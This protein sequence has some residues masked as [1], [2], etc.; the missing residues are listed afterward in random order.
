[1]LSTDH[2]PL[3]S[4]EEKEWNSGQSNTGNPVPGI[5]SNE[6]TSRSMNFYNCSLIY[7][8]DGRT[9]VLITDFIGSSLRSV[10]KGRLYCHIRNGARIMGSVFDGSSATDSNQN[11][12]ELS[13]S[14]DA[15]NRNISDI[16]YSDN[17]IIDFFYFNWGQGSGFVNNYEVAL[18]K[19]G[20]KIFG[21]GF[22]E[23]PTQPMDIYS[24]NP[25]SR[26][27]TSNIIYNENTHDNVKQAKIKEYMGIRNVFSSD[28]FGN[29]P[30]ANI[31]A[32]VEYGSEYTTIGDTKTMQVDSNPVVREYQTSANGKFEGTFY[33]GQNGRTE[34][35]NSIIVPVTDLIFGSNNDNSRL[36]TFDNKFFVKFFN[37]KFGGQFYIERDINTNSDFTEFESDKIFTLIEDEFVSVTSQ[38]A[39]QIANISLSISTEID[40]TTG[41]ASLTQNAVIS[42]TISLQNLY[43]YFRYWVT[44]IGQWDY[45]GNITVDNSIL[46]MDNWN[47]SF[48]K[49]YEIDKRFTKLKVNKFTLP[50][51]NEY[52]QIENLEANEIIVE[53][54][55][56]YRFNNVTTNKL[57]N[58]TSTTLNVFIENTEITEFVGDISFLDSDLKINIPPGYENDIEIY[59]SYEN[60]SLRTNRIGFIANANSDTFQ[61]SS[62]IHGGNKLYFRSIDSTTNEGL[63]I[64][65]LT[66]EMNAGSHEKNIFV[67][68]EQKA[69]TII[70]DKL[71]NVL[72]DTKE[73]TTKTAEIETDTT[74]VK[75]KLSEMNDTILETE[76]DVTNIKNKTIEIE[77]DTT[78][79]KNKLSEMNDTILETELDVTDIKNKTTEVIENTSD[80]KLKVVDIW[81]D[82]ALIEQNT[83]DIKADVIAGLKELPVEEKDKYKGSFVSTAS[84]GEFSDEQE[85]LLRERFDAVHFSIQTLENKLVELGLTNVAVDVTTIKD[86]VDI[87]LP[88][89]RDIVI[90]LN[91]LLSTEPGKDLDD[92]VLNSTTY[93]N[94]IKLI[95]EN[96]DKN[97]ATVMGGIS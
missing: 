9:N 36:T 95:K 17:K 83:D 6:A 55:K 13:G 29:S 62:I 42:D 32:Y 52:Q 4:N 70:I 11:S 45:R 7:E 82:V 90:A 44:E 41:F 50:I 74:D 16:I 28:I 79:V 85:T 80:T 33:N 65:D 3:G 81:N 77:T 49:E 89:K 64:E 27:T 96:L 14:G 97:K 24:I 72:N 92:V 39:S 60:A 53:E 23:A 34:N 93:G 12:L 68:E 22:G 57:I 76:L 26:I 69:L 40:D 78:D 2:S 47:V 56:L 21:F 38:E 86:K 46:S 48:H 31:K 25:V 10:E 35:V 84:T 63:I 8:N 75:N 58:N 73:I 5:P 15:P 71:D 67:T 61:Y 54:N 66:M 20:G 91:S 88:E 43:N 30:I 19:F 37:Y 18:H 94:F 87:D 1:M 51:G 59:T